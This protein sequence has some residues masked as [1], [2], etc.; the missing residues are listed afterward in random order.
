MIKEYQRRPKSLNLESSAPNP[1]FFPSF[2]SSN[3][4]QSETRRPLSVLPRLTLSFTPEYGDEKD[5][6]PLEK[7]KPTDIATFGDRRVV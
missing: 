6:D 1:I 5:G 4:A 3:Q 7:R 2:D